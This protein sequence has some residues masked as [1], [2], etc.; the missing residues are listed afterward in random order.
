MRVPWCSVVSDY[1]LAKNGVKRGGVL[2]PVLFCL[3]IDAMLI[4]LSD[5]NACCYMGLIFVGALAYA[6]DIVMLAP[7]VN[8]LRRLLA[9]CD[10]FADRFNISFNAQKSKC[11]IFPPRRR[12]PIPRQINMPTFQIGNSPTELVTSY[13]HLGY[14]ITNQLLDTKW[15]GQ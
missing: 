5:A 9:V 10:D 4:S 6:D 14:V 13:C 1:F 11:M 3:Y 12:G 15:Q 2:S 8:A 7:T